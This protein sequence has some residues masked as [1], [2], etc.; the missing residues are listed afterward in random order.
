MDRARAWLAIGILGAVGACSDDSAPCKSKFGSAGIE[1]TAS[2][3]P[4]ITSYDV[5]PSQV[6]VG[7]AVHLSAVAQDPN[8]APLTFTWSASGGTIADAHASDTTFTCT[9]VGKPTIMV[10]VSNGTCDDTAS[11]PVDCVAK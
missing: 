6:I 4:S 8:S 7:S 3:C 9:A 11:A 10:Q 1:A 2:A 5:E